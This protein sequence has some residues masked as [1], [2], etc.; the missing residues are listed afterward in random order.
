MERRQRLLRRR[1]SVR[2]DGALNG[3]C[4][5]NTESHDRRC[6]PVVRGEESSIFSPYT[7]N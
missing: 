7:L 4:L 2:R 1:G 3:L 5:R 6:L